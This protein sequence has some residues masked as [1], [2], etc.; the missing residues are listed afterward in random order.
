MMHKV[1]DHML[2]KSCHCFSVNTVHTVCDGQEMV[3][4]LLAVVKQKQ[5]N[6]F[7]SFI[8][9]ENRNLSSV[10]YMLHM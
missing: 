6:V 7:F 5:G 9:D 1:Q 8:R 4:S 2:N 10:A 3:Y